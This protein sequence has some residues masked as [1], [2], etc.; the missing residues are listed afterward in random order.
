MKARNFFLFSLFLAGVGLVCSPALA[1][2]VPPHGSTAPGPP[3]FFSS[4]LAAGPNA[5]LTLTAFNA[6]HTRSGQLHSF[7]PPS[8]KC[9]VP[10]P[11]P[12]PGTL[13]L[14]GTGLLVLGWGFIRRPRSPMSGRK[15]GNG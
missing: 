5:P 8:P 2:T 15:D 12:E 10:P 14:L 9:V 4:T 11:V 3:V 1:H 6:N 7:A 13:L